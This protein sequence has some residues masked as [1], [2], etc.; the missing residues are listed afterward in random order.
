MIDGAVKQNVRRA[1]MASGF[2][3]LGAGVVAMLL[4]GCQKPTDEA[5]P[6]VLSAAM[7]AVIAPQAQVLWDISNRALNANGDPDGSKLTDADWAKVVNAG[8]A[9]REEAAKLADASTL[10]VAPP[11]EKIQDEGNPGSSAAAQVQGY[12]N[13]DRP[14]W[15]QHARAL[16]VAGER[17]V[18]ASKVRDA[19][20]L[21]DVANSLDQVC[22]SCHQKFWYPEQAAPAT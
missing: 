11:G 19:A 5:A 2:H 16:S 12:L 7:K 4:T 3:V 8:N 1:W 6:V 18:A 20:K 9:V 13:G 21:A 14:G 15:T 17:A 22:E 10:V